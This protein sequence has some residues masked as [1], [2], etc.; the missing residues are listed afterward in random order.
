MQEFSFAHGMVG[1][2]DNSSRGGLCGCYDDE[3]SSDGGEGG[4]TGSVGG[5]TSVV[6]VSELNS[7]YRWCV[8]GFDEDGDL[9]FSINIERSPCDDEGAA[10]LKAELAVQ[11]L[12]E[13]GE[14]DE[15]WHDVGYTM[16]P[17]I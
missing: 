2:Y 14:L 11:H 16:Y 9:A 5:D 6:V 7:R 17:S 4:A 8:R 3:D 13:D 1:E 15:T 12:I 10:L